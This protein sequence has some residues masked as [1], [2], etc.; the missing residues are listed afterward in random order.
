MIKEIDQLLCI[1][2]GLCDNVCPTDVLR[3]IDEKV[4]IVYPDDCCHCMEC[5]FICPTEAIVLTPE[6]PKKF[7]ASLRWEQIKAALSPSG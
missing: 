1:N 2:C 3:R 6:V 5:L 7:N 4:Q